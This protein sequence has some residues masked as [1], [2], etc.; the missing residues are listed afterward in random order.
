MSTSAGTPAALELT[1]ES[2]AAG[3]EGVG[4]DAGGPTL[5]SDQEVP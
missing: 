4:H 2:L 3:G 5:G 1:I